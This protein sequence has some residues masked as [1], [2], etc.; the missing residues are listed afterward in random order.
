M[1]RIRFHGRGGQGMKTAANM[2]GDALFASGY[3]VQDAPRYGAE[4]RG[5]PMVA[6]V[7]AGHD[8]IVERGVIAVPDLVVVADP[9]LIGIA[10][11]GVMQGVS[12][13]TTMFVNTPE[14]SAALRQRLAYPGCVVTWP[15]GAALPA[16]A[17]AALVSPA[18]VGAAARLLGVVRRELLAQAVAVHDS[19]RSGVAGDGETNPGL[20]AYDALVV[21]A[22]CVEMQPEGF[23]FDHHVDPDWIFLQAEPAERAAPDIHVPATSALANTGTWRS[24][25][26]V[27][28]EALCN[29]CSWVCSTLCPDSAIRVDEDRRPIIDY[30]HCKGCM[31]CMMACPPHAIHQ[32]AEADAERSA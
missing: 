30:D 7:R 25:R 32:V 19:H 29:R 9:T 1:F 6:F 12:S 10:A 24:F 20:A 31:I 17:R 11:A 28:D 26:P 21:H 5:A 16:G 3:E 13:H 22:G 4:R 14:S 23:F 2:L 27:I 8:P 18:C 15:P